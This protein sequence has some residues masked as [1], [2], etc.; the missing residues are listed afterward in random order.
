MFVRNQLFGGR[1]TL[2]FCVLSPT[3]SCLRSRM[4]NFAI[5]QRTIVKIRTPHG[6]EVD[7]IKS[8]FF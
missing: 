8:L 7:K 5:K 1:L 6:T 4:T 3:C 2:L